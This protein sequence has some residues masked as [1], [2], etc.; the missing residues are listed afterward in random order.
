MKPM[1]YFLGCAGRIKIGTTNDVPAR[2]REIAL[3]LFEDV[4]LLAQVR[5]GA[6]LETAIHKRLKAF[7]LRNEWFV[8]CPEVRAVMADVQSRGPEAVKE[9]YRQV[10]HAT[11]AYFYDDPETMVSSSVRNPWQMLVA[12]IDDFTMLVMARRYPNHEAALRMLK[13]RR[14][15]VIKLCEI[16][17]QLPSDEAQFDRAADIVEATQEEL[18]AIVGRNVK[19]LFTARRR[20]KFKFKTAGEDDA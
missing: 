3:H 2:I 12:R 9:F 1:V 13:R 10:N 16:A 4:V 19:P 6:T 7:A 5:G 18:N 8:D 20:H 14:R 11:R 17:K 15:S